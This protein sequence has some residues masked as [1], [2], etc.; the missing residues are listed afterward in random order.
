MTKKIASNTLGKLTGKSERFHS[1]SRFWND[2]RF[3]LVR[4]K[5]IVGS[6]FSL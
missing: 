6:E 2:A 3:K 4:N 1:S 5:I